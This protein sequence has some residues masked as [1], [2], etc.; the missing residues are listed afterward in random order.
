MNDVSKES[1]SLVPYQGQGIEKKGSRLSSLFRRGKSKN[2]EDRQGSE[3]QALLE[4]IDRSF[5][6]V[7]TAL[8]GLFKA[9]GVDYQLI[10]RR[11]LEAGVKMYPRIEEEFEGLLPAEVTSFV[12]QF[13]RSNEQLHIKEIV[14]ERIKHHGHYGGVDSYDPYILMEVGTIEEYF[15]TEEKTNRIPSPEGN[16]I[17]GNAIHLQPDKQ[18]QWKASAMLWDS[19]EVDEQGLPKGKTSVPE[20]GVDL[21]L[22]RSIAKLVPMNPA[23]SPVLSRMIALTPLN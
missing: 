8:N 2:E 20:I 14:V 1:S 21:S 9:N 15:S 11:M 17:G 13:Y 3:Y 18:G 7:G 4:A 6:P 10:E 19:A 23:I 5:D 16:L 12:S 22:I